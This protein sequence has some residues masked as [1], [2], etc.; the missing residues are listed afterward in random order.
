[1]AV[2]RMLPTEQA[3]ELIA[4]TRDIADK[5]LTPIVDEH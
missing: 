2:D 1:M 5:V 3:E 4:L